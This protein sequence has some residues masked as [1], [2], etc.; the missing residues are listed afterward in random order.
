VAEYPSA[1]ETE[2]WRDEALEA[3]VEFAMSL[4][5]TVRSLRADYELTGKQRT[6]LFVQCA[7]EGVQR[8]LELYGKMVGT[9]C[10]SQVTVLGG[11]ETGIP[12]GCAVVPV[13]DKCRA[14]LLLAGLVDKER[15]SRKL[16]DRRD[17]LNQQIGKL[18]EVVSRA[19]Y[20]DKVPEEV[21]R[22]NDDRKTAME[23]EL[24]HILEALDGLSRM[25]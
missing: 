25:A 13:S 24:K 9:L 14:H 21:R 22:A 6:E 10:N 23:G 17:K 3:D 2:G 16:A 11:A 4:V 18:A 7:D 1:A 12:A 5:R 15:E 20:V 8:R 19:D